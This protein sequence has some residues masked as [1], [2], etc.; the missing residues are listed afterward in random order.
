MAHSSNKN[1]S[2][3]INFFLD[4]S[5]SGSDV[6]LLWFHKGSIV[7][8]ALTADPALTSYYPTAEGFHSGNI[9]LILMLQKYTLK[10]KID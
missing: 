2:I 9:W 10:W 5:C 1:K 7:Y 8:P 3:N 4:I 6:S